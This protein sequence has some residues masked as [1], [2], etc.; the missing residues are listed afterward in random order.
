MLRK[1]GRVVAGGV[2]TALVLSLPGP[3][4]AVMPTAAETA[5]PADIDAARAG[6]LSLATVLG[7]AGTLPQL[8][9]PLPLT[10]QAPTDVAGLTT[11]F[12]DAWGQAMRGFATSGQN[13]TW[14]Q[15]EAALDRDGDLAVDAT[16][17]DAGNGP[18]R[19]SL[20]LDG[21]RT[22]TV[23]VV[24]AGAAGSSTD[25]LFLDG[26]SAPTGA[27]PMTATY[28]GTLELRLDETVLTEGGRIDPARALSLDPASEL[29]LD[30]AG[31]G[32]DLELPSRYGF[33]DVTATGTAGYRL[34]LTLPFADPDGSG[35]IPRA[36]WEQT[37]IGDLVDPERGT[38]SGVNVALG[39][40]S[41]LVAG[42]DDGTLT[43]DLSADQL[44]P[45]A[46]GDGSFSYP[47]PQVAVGEGL[48]DL[49]AVTP[50]DAIVGLAQVAAAYGT[51]Q[52]RIDPQL[53]FADT[54]I[55]ELVSLVDPLNEVVEGQGSAAVS[56]GRANTSPPAATAIPGTTWYC[57]ARTADAVT[58]GSV[59]WTLH[60]EG[61]I[62]AGSGG[63]DTVGQEPTSNVVVTGSAT[64]P[65]I[66]VDFTVPATTAGG[67]AVGFT[68]ERRIRTAQELE[69][70][71]ARLAGADIGVA[72]DADTRSLRYDLGLTAD[73]AATDLPVTVADLLR[74]RAHLRGVELDSEGGAPA[75]MSLDVAETTLAGTYGLLLAPE[76]P[77]AGDA[78]GDAD[79]DA[80]TTEV[81]VAERAYLDTDPDQPEL[82]IAGLSSPGESFSGTGSVGFVPVDVAL[83]GLSLSSSGMRA[84]IAGGALETGGP[85]DLTSAALLSDILADDVP[86]TEGAAMTGEL[87]VAAQATATVSSPLLPRSGTA[88]FAQSVEAET[89]S[90]APVPLPEVELDDDYRSHVA[91][92]ELTPQVT[93]R[94]TAGGSDDT[95]TAAGA[96][97]ESGAF[98]I[99]FRGLG[100]ADRVVNATL[101]NVSTGASCPRF[102]VVS[103]SEL[104]CVDVDGTTTTAMAGD[105]AAEDDQ[106]DNSWRVGDDFLVEGD[107]L[108][109]RS[110]LLDSLTELSLGFQNSTEDSWNSPLPM[111]G[112]TP[113]D[114][115][116]R[117]LVGVSDLAV[118]ISERADAETSDKT[119]GLAP[120]DVVALEKA[121]EEEAQRLAGDTGEPD[122]TDL[123]SVAVSDTGQTLD[124]VPHLVL[125]L[126]VPAQG[127]V[128]APLS[129]QL[130]DLGYWLRR[131]ALPAAGSEPSGEARLPVSWSSTLDLDLALP[132][133]RGVDPT[134]V[135]VLPSTGVSALTLTLDE[136]EV[137]LTGS[138]GPVNVT[139]GESAVIEGTH[140]E[141]TGTNTSVVLD[142]VESTFGGTATGGGDALVDAARD[143]AALDAAGALAD[144]AAPQGRATVEN[145]TRDLT[146][147]AGTPDAAA[148][149][150]LPCPLPLAAEAG[151]AEAA[152]G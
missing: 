132:L 97:F 80:G 131:D 14:D 36:E 11:A 107:P 61:E 8:A 123:V 2:S 72:Y 139:L 116:E 56:C 113:K 67:E 51:A 6:L 133:A 135:K 101:F 134:A 76:A 63:A 122:A 110:I 17:S 142:G 29:T 103:D 28:G 58:P 84:D 148:S 3:A 64:E 22:G 99:D 65:D 53:P 85:E 138:L 35:E 20:E 44:Q 1:F 105:A 45:V 150:T 115:L 7:S 71:L 23:Y 46:D 95:L 104:R 126:A 13:Q 128:A 10:G 52:A 98:G 69:A 26:T 106:V 81:T 90:T 137:D 86:G 149:S 88:T 120:V 130:P 68:A 4:F 136:R 38:E 34:T 30:L 54:R 47:E 32:D 79:G 57:Q 129:F 108:T 50:S 140:Q 93:G 27:I 127:T 5:P 75:A 25:Q 37:L 121:L 111:V 18:V 66:S 145:T 82:Q 119:T 70:R 114:L 43:Q 33:S 31:T 42:D 141:V 146:C 15:L 89:P 118:A 109:T 73:P 124:G 49:D 21:S 40:D 83:D 92:L 19:I 152:D 77:D 60:S 144:A 16:V 100:G 87:Q 12:D 102:L 9:T 112:L 74:P 143:F 117:Q 62:V 147:A 48:A 125:K 91:P 55:S 59:D 94:S 39:L 78:A 96:D 41:D 151:G 24:H